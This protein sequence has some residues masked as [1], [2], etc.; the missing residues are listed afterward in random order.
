MDFLTASPLGFFL[1]LSTLFIGF[2][3]VPSLLTALFGV[4]S[5]ALAIIAVRRSE[6]GGK[7]LAAVA[8][9]LGTIEIAL[10]SFRLAL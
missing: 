5:V 3:S 8:L 6:V 10:V 2:V 7:F 4:V 9:V 1:L